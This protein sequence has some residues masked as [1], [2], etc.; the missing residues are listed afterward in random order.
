MT[1]GQGA[2]RPRSAT[3]SQ[4]VYVEL[5]KGA[6]GESSEDLSIALWY[7]ALPIAPYKV[8]AIEHD[9]S[10]EF[11]FEPDCPPGGIDSYLNKLTQGLD[12]A[13]TP[14]QY[15]MKR[16]CLAGIK[17]TRAAFPNPKAYCSQ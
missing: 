8:F 12:Q 10:C 1:E 13:S 6:D 16:Q 4:K 2:C 3:S 17:K 11:T 14:A 5:K 9:F 15:K 7:S